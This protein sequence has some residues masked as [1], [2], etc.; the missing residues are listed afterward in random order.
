MKAGRSNIYL[1]FTSAAVFNYTAFI[2]FDGLFLY[3]VLF[4]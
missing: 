1:F 2:F 3:P 4:I